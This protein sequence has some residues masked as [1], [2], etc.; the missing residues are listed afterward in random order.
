[1]AESIKRAFVGVVLL[2]GIFFILTVWE[3]QMR[4]PERAHH[5][6]ITFPQRH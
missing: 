3:G 1:M 5:A 4:H 2:S 6:L